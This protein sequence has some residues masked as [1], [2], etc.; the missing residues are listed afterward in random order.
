M[1]RPVRLEPA[2]FRLEGRRSFQL[3]HLCPI[4][5]KRFRV[6]ATIHLLP[7][8]SHGVNPYFETVFAATLP[9]RDPTP[10]SIQFLS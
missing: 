1:A 2:P 10:F 8:V 3:S 9:G 6:L 4:D 7:F 5:S